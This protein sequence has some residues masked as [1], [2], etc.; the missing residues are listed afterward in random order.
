[1]K[2]AHFWLDKDM[3]SQILALAKRR[4]GDNFSQAC[5]YLL[6]KALAIEAAGDSIDEISVLISKA[7]RRELKPTEDRLAKL[8]A[9]AAIAAGTSMFLNYFVIREAPI[10]LDR[11]T[12]EIYEEA[13]KKAVAM[14]REKDIEKAGE[15]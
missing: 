6:N 9:K 1:M 12:K 13:R 5:R 11:S 2:Q 3:N 10:G 4:F 15:F 8:T 14:L 7:V